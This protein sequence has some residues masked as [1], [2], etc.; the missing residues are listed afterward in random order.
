MQQIIENVYTF[1]GLIAGRVY[2]LK[3]SDGFTLIDASIP[4][5][6]G[7]ILKQLAAAGYQPHDVKRILITH[8]HPDH[9]GSLPDLKAQTG[10]NV[11]VG[12]ADVAIAEGRE[13]IARNNTAFRPPKT[14]VKGTPVDV[15]IEDGQLFPEILGGLQA[16]HTP[17]HSL[18]HMAFWQAQSRL[19]FTGD[20]MFHLMGVTQPPSFLTVNME[21][22]RQSIRHLADL[23]AEIVCFGHGNPIL[24]D[25]K[26]ALNQLVAKFS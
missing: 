25:G 26:A 12:K 21:Q 8:A 16:V 24:S 9:V 2:A 14:F 15:A 11:Y 5:S 13:D 22:N 23:G 7:K 19:L 18:G 6:A 17:G 1:T 10:A 4:N 3:D 20:V